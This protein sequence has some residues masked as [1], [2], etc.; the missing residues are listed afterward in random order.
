VL[1]PFV[2]VLEEAR[3]G[4]SA[5]AAFTCYDLEAAAAVLETAALRDRAVIVLVSPGSVVGTG[6]ESFLAAL[7][8][9]AERA[10]ARSCV[11]VDHVDDLRLIARVLELGVGAVMADG[12]RLSLEEN[13]ALVREAVRLG[14]ATGAGIE[15]ELGRVEGDEDLALAARDGRLT[16]PDHA[17]RFVAE[18][19]ASCL[20]VS[21]GNSHGRY[22]MPPNLDWSR[23]EAIHSQV[24]APLSLHGASGIPD[25]SI[26]H[27]VELGIMKVNVNTEL[28]EAYLRATVGAVNGFRETAA[29]IDLHRAQTAAV[30]E[31][32][33]AKLDLYS[34]E[35]SR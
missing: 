35:R 7:L 3:S 9:Y 21:I 24:D 27:A 30:A 34:P 2:D 29:L 22:R 26:R 4:G 28:R 18:S 10:P 8:A 20:A 25:V 16:E 17:Q 1:I 32:V 33:A 23:L 14:T 11:Q 15:A 5:A 13:I 31:V 12:S 6:G 19:G